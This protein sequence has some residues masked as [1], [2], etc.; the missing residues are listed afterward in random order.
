MAYVRQRGNQLAI[1]HGVRDPETKKVEQQILFTIY[2]QAEALAA[3][4]KSDSAAGERFRTMLEAAHPRIRFDWREVRSGI[5]ENLATLPESYDYAATRLRGRFREDL[6]AFAKQLILADPWT[7]AA[8]SQLLSA[9]R[10]E[11]EYLRELIDWRLE[12]PEA[13][14]DQGSGDDDFL[15]RFATRDLRVP[16]DMEE[17][18]ADLYEK[19]E[20][21]RAI[22]AFKI[23]TDTFED[24]AEGHNYL[25]L[26]ALD[27]ERLDEAI[28]HF[29]KTMELGR[30]L[31]PK[32][33]AKDRWWSDHA[34]RPFMRGLQ[35]LALA[36]NQA[37]RFDESLAACDR[38]HHEC[39]DDITAAA[40]RASVYLNTARWQQAYDA[41]RFIHQVSPSESL[42]AAF[43]AFELG[44]KGDARAFFTHASLN[45]PNTVAMVIGAK[46]PRPTT[47]EEG[48][49]HNTGVSMLRALA[50]Y[51]EKRK[52]DA[53]RFFTDLWKSDQQVG[54]RTEV[55]NAT[56]R[57][58]ADR[59]NKE[60][61][62]FERMTQ[63][64]TW[65]FARQ[66]SPVPTTSPE[67]RAAVAAP[68][69]NH[70]SSSSSA[71]KRLY[72]GL[73]KPY[74]S[75]KV[76]RTDLTG[77]DFTDC[78]Y[79]ALLYAPGSRGVVLVL[80]VSDEEMETKVTE[81]LWLG[82]PAKRFV[83]W[84][85]FDSF[86]TGVL[87]AKDLRAVI[88]RKGVAAT[89]ADYKAELL[90]REIRDR[91]GERRP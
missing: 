50:G 23:L 26:I 29:E 14:A 16:Y 31:F 44:T 63:M 21:P 6:L 41:A 15:W 19:R 48:K 56:G 71:S 25:G 47:G 80:D 27:E 28:A 18:A 78:P 65:E 17:E 34:T 32:K 2:S 35:N 11:L 89:D 37:K 22:V 86:I 49:D 61:G 13:P 1:V 76:N 73:K 3:L 85:K 10:G 70:Q 54:F 69:V 12:S 8:S 46:L 58:R 53:R 59:K 88:G 83:V 45:C 5:E 62:A 77:A 52:P 84:G 30:R 43:A 81:E 82:V 38:L 4:G 39:H 33:I 36:L 87:P 20:Y 79:T 9:H 90:K 72:R 57:W 66:V 55:K 42:V 64:R 68:T 40:H 74:Q 75:D 24:Y 51:L 60:R 7:F 67:P 91:L